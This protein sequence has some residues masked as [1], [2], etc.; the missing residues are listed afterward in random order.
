MYRRLGRT[1]SVHV[2]GPSESQF[3]R[4]LNNFEYGNF[5]SGEERDSEKKCLAMLPVCPIRKEFLQLLSYSDLFFHS[6]LVCKRKYK[7]VVHLRPYAFIC[8]H[9]T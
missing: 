7:D 6:L 9:S 5:D 1:Y 2:H 8:P 4:T 3:E